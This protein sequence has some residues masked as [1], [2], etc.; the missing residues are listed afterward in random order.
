MS[1]TVNIEKTLKQY[2]EVTDVTRKIVI[3]KNNEYGQSWIIARPF[4]ILEQAW[5]KLKRIRT[6]QEEQ[7]EMKIIDEPIE[8]D[9]NHIINYCIFGLILIEEK[10]LKNFSPKDLIGKYNAV[11]QK[12]LD[13]CKNKNHDY[14]EAWR[15][16]S[17]STMVDLMLMKCIRA[18]QMHRNRADSPEKIME[19]FKDIMNYSIFCKIKINE[20]EDP[21]L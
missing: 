13:L 16:L 5:I 4:S 3:E 11:I 6:A 17:I 21:L 15:I 18:Q 10:P 8:D 20:G 2:A 7:G 14:G 19:I 12:V 9:F 1:S